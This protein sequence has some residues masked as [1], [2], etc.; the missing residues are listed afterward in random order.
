MSQ[1]SPGT[2]AGSAA[3]P[4][5]KLGVALAPLVPRLELDAECAVLLEGAASAE[6]AIARLEAAGKMIEACRVVAHSLP[7]REAVWWACMCARGAPPDPVQTAADL[8]ALEAAEGWVRRPDEA[9]RRAAMA[10]AEAAKFRSTEAWAAVGAFWSGGSMAPE[11]QP[12]VPPPEHLTGV[13]VSGAVVLA[14][15]RAEVNTHAARLGRFLASARD[16]GLGGAGRVPP[17]AA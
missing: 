1:S 7:K 4:R 11:G 13:A 15:V 16:I 10:A 5:S 8:A 2:A 12:A 14:A 6:E 17:E 9:N 3:A